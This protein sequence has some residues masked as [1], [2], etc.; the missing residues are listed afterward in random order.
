M[1]YYDWCCLKWS[2]LNYAVSWKRKRGSCIAI[3]YTSFH[4]FAW[5]QNVNFFFFITSA[6]RQPII[7][8]FESQSDDG[9]VLLATINSTCNYREKRKPWQERYLWISRK[10]KKS[11]FIYPDYGFHH[12]INVLL[13]TQ[14]SVLGL[15]TCSSKKVFWFSFLGKLIDFESERADWIESKLN[16]AWV[17]TQIESSVFSCLFCPPGVLQINPQ[18]KRSVVTDAF[19]GTGAWWMRPSGF[20]NGLRLR[21]SQRSC[22]PGWSIYSFGGDPV[23]DSTCVPTSLWQTDAGKAHELWRGHVRRFRMNEF[24]EKR[25]RAESSADIATCSWF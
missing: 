5:V 12:Q 6:F 11:F 10:K 7:Q 15:T 9:Q 16:L 20:W 18:P 17:F 21:A 13:S 22:Y 14:R 19:S 24:V 23:N 2:Y 8:V 3:L 4:T 25:R 1:H